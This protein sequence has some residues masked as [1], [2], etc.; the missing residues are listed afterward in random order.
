MRTP[1]GISVTMIARLDHLNIEDA[2]VDVDADAD[3]AMLMRSDWLHTR[4]DRGKPASVSRKK[5]PEGEPVRL[6]GLYAFN[7]QTHIPRRANCTV[8]VGLIGPSD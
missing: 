8:S 3:T 5:S 4:S 7:G 6:A 2:D 1:S